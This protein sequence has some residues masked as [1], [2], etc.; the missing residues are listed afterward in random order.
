MFWIVQIYIILENDKGWLLPIIFF[1]SLSKNLPSSPEQYHLTEPLKLQQSS[2][3]PTGCC[4]S[5]SDFGNGW[6]G[7][8]GE[9]SN[10]LSAFLINMC[11]HNILHIYDI[12]KLHPYLHTLLYYFGLYCNQMLLKVLSQFLLENIDPRLYLMLDPKIQDTTTER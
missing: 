3:G 12:C 8:K 5:G 10:K 6:E 9:G 4:E 2:Q 7:A 11:V 1:K